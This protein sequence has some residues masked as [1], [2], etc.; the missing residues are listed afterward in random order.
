MN[1]NKL[2]IGG[3]LGTVAY[4]IV[5][6]VVWLTFYNNI[7]TTHTLSGIMKSDEEANLPVLI[8]ATLAYGFLLSYVITSKSGMNLSKGFVTGT[9]IGLLV[10]ATFDLTF[11]A[12]SK[13]FK[14]YKIVLLDIVLYAF[15]SGIAGAVIGWQAHRSKSS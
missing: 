11:Y 15:V 10:N 12:S 6:M 9:V 13:I 2:I 4:F 1:T 7:L 3:L 8:V 5:N 14:G